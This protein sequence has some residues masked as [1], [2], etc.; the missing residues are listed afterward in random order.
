M[1]NIRVIYDNA[2]DRATLSSTA[3]ATGLGVANLLSDIKSRVCRS[4]G[5]SITITATWTNAETIGGV[6]LA[7]T[8]LS[9]THTI[10]VQAYTNTADTTAVLDTGAVLGAAASSPVGN[11]WA[12]TG[13]NAFAYGGGTYSRVWFASKVSA[14]KIVVTVTDA[15]NT[16]GYIDIGRFICGDYWMPTVGVEMGS[17]LTVTDT[18]EH[19]RTE[20]G[21]LHTHIG[22]KHRKQSLPMGCL[23]TN[24]RAQMWN[25]LWSNGMAKPLFISLF[26]NNADTKLEQT[27]QMYGKLVQQPVMSTAYWNIMSA[28]IEVEEV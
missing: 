7:F 9:A 6:A 25:I 24:D 26:P 15:A 21:D 23:D 1:A 14:K 10:R 3:T 22:T 20:A 16:Q 28:T 18:S 27:H 13:V 2:A 12:N 19:F 4:S 8:N 5:T 17:T 11:G